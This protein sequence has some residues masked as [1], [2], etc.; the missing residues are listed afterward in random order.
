M[1]FHSSNGFVTFEI[2]K[3]SMELVEL[4]DILGVCTGEKILFIDC[5]S[6]S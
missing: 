6:R 3:V 2:D 5:G 4:V 1:D